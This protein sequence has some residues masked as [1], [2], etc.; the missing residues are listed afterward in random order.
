MPTATLLLHLID[1]ASGV[2]GPIEDDDNW[3]LED[4]L[5]SRSGD[6]LAS[7]R[8]DLTAIQTQ[9]HEFNHIAIYNA[10]DVLGLT[11]EDVHEL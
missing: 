8:V 6:V 9:C 5:M 3:D 7:L 4:I 11:L 1:A 10:G 2:S